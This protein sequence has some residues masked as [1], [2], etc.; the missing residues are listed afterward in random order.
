MLDP[1]FHAFCVE[2][3]TAAEFTECKILIFIHN[4]IAHAAIFA[5]LYGSLLDPFLFLLE[6]I[7]S[8]ENGVYL[9]INI[10]QSTIV[11]LEDVASFL[12]QGSLGIGRSG[13]ALWPL[14][15][16]V[17]PTTRDISCP[18]VEDLLNLSIIER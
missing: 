11:L 14:C 9:V 5:W 15:V 12:M 1:A 13:S 2:I 4:V 18:A 17:W 3:P 8:T 10:H 16:G 6:G 7:G